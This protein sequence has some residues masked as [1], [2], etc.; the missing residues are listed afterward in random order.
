MTWRYW[1]L[2]VLCAAAPVVAQDQAGQDQAVQE[3]VADWRLSEAQVAA[4]IYPELAF[5]PSANDRDNYEKYFYFHRADTSFNEAYGDIRE[6]DALAGGTTSYASSG[7]PYPGYYASQ[8]GIGGV[9]GGVLGSVLADA[10]HGS[11]ARRKAKRINMRNCMAFKGYDRYG[12]SKDL[13]EAFNFEEGNGRK[14]DEDR[15]RVM[16]QQAL[17]ASGPRP[18]A[19]VI[20]P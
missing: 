15:Q 2:P 13:W 14:P 10:I 12:L 16:Q 9:I 4:V 20:I 1:V 3:M 6:C 8:Y 18:A 5:E 19:E 11:A 17:I 7:E